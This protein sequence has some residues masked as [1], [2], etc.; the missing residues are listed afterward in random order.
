MNPTRTVSECMATGLHDEMRA[1][2]MTRRFNAHYDAR[3]STYSGGVFDQWTC[4][5]CGNTF[6]V[7]VIE[8]ADDDGERQA[9]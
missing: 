1:N 5:H 8:D 3:W 4:L 7:A 2:P 6:N 9:A